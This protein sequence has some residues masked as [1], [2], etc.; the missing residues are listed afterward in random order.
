MHGVG[1]N[2]FS[3]RSQ[4]NKVNGLATFKEKYVQPQLRLSIDNLT[5]HLTG[6]RKDFFP[7]VPFL[8]DETFFGFS[9]D[10]NTNYTLDVNS[11]DIVIQRN[12]GR[13][14]R[15]VPNVELDVNHRV[16]AAR[17]ISLIVL[18][19]QSLLDLIANF[20]LLGNLKL[21]STRQSM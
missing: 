20:K 2:S 7:L 8:E 9:N 11:T 10:G 16:N 15:S 17:F 6:S 14:E 5:L 12:G 13:F 4:E 3:L 1:L 18:H 21:L 19:I